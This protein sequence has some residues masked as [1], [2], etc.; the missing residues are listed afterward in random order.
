MTVLHLPNWHIE[1]EKNGSLFEDIFLCIF[2]NE[3]V[4]ILINISLKFVPEAQ[5]NNIPILV[6]IM[7]WRRPGTRK[8]FRILAF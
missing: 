2:L 4:W 5:I 3:K 6:Q 8:K 1:A 7:A